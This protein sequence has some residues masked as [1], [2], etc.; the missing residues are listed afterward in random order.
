MRLLKYFEKR[1]KEL[2][3]FYDGNEFLQPNL[4]LQKLNTNGLR[5]DDLDQ[6]DEATDS[7]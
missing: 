7:N 3:L 4:K 6:N 5:M 2:G 1:S